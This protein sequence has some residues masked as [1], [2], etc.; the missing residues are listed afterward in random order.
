MTQLAGEQNE[1]YNLEPESLI[2]RSPFP[3]LFK[4]EQWILTNGSSWTLKAQH[5]K[6]INPQY[7]GVCKVTLSFFK[8][9]NL[10]P[11]LY[12]YRGP[13]PFPAFILCFTMMPHWSLNP[14]ISVNPSL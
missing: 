12:N 3:G 2:K 4:V 1:K 13:K 7:N 11:P 14:N 6:M 5:Y 8:S 9:F 10:K